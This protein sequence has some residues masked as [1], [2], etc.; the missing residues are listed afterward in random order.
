MCGALG[1]LGEG[2]SSEREREGAR[3]VEGGVGGRGIQAAGL[4]LSVQNR[5]PT[6]LVLS[7]T[8]THTCAHTPADER[9][10]Y[11]DQQRACLE[12]G[13]RKLTD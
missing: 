6:V 2:N 11:S 9:A 4:C 10:V 3:G 13:S 1:G 5:G 8:H 7:H 12:A